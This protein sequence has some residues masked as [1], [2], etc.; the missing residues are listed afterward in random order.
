MISD[1]RGGHVSPGVYTEERDVNYTVN[2][3][4]I[5]SLGRVGEALK[6]PAFQAIPIKSWGE[7]VDYFGGNR[8][9]YSFVFNSIYYGNFRF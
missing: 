6:G 8:C 5:T 2:S 1:A 4:G 3:L 9:C 7:Y